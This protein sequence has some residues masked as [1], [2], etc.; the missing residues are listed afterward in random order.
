MAAPVQ[1]TDPNDEPITPAQAAIFC[2]AQGYRFVQDMQDPDQPW[3]VVLGSNDEY[4]EWLRDRRITINALIK[5]IKFIGPRP[6]RPIFEGW[7][8]LKVV[9]IPTQE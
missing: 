9:E 6:A 1:F 7:S 8:K 5:A 3:A 2:A 4:W